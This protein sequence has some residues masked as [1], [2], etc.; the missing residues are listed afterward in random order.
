MYY[1]LSITVEQ[2]TTA[3]GPSSF[4]AEEA[5]TRIKEGL[6]SPLYNAKGVTNAKLI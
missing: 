5:T 4:A 3:A 2:F 6:Q 1:D